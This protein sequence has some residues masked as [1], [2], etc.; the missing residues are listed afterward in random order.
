[1]SGIADEMQQF[2]G[3]NT[4]GFTIQDVGREFPEKISGEE[5]VQLARISL[6]LVV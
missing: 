4:F 6:S 1:M 3:R 5:R 2:S